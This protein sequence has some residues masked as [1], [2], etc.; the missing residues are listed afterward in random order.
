MMLFGRTFAEGRLPDGS[1][2]RDDDSETLVCRSCW[3]TSDGLRLSDLYCPSCA[4]KA[5]STP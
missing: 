4:T 3:S 1:L 5:D 2:P